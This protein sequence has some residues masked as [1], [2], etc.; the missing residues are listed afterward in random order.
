MRSRHC[1]ANRVPWNASISAAEATMS[2]RVYSET[3][4]QWSCA[5]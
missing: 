2:S 4:T 1:S 3:A 5:R